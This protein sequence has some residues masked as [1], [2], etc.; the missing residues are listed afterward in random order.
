MDEQIMPAR[1]VR[2][3]HTE[4]SG[5]FAAPEFGP[6]GVVDAGAVMF[7]RL[8]LPRPTW[9]DAAA[10]SRAC[11]CSASTRASTWCRPTRA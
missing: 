5:S 9:H 7:R 3:V 2:K 1:E 6:L 10:P 4:S 11:A 8:T